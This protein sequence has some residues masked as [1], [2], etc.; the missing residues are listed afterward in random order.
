M[1]VNS[2]YFNLNSMHVCIFVRLLSLD[3]QVANDAVEILKAIYSLD[4]LYVPT[5]NYSYREILKPIFTLNM[6][7][8]SSG[9]DPLHFKCKICDVKVKKVLMRL[10]ISRHF[11]EETSVPSSCMYCGINCNNP[12]KIAVTSDFGSLATYGPVETGCTSY[13]YFSLACAARKSKNQPS[14]NRQFQCAICDN[15]FCSYFMENHYAQSHVGVACPNNL[16]IGEDE[17][18]AVLLTRK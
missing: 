18:K 10:H 17:K 12:L 7:K 9:A 11:L 13:R 16:I 2:N 14:S 3:R 1:Q 6:P 8:T 4:F 5:T 15:I